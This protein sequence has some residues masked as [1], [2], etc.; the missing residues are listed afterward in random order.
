MRTTV[1]NAVCLTLILSGCGEANNDTRMINNENGNA[2]RMLT[3]ESATKPDAM[4]QMARTECA[5]QTD[6]FVYI[7]L[8]PD[9]APKA[10]PFLEREEETMAFE[11]RLKRRADFERGFWDCRRFKRSEEQCLPKSKGP[12][13]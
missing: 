10:W 6:C 5:D 11:Y 1:L 13:E 9:S 7:W 4:M 2:V 8:K 12:A 3:V